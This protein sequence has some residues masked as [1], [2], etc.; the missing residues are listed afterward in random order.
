[1]LL[2]RTLDVTG[3]LM[4]ESVCENISTPCSA[5]GRC[6]EYL[7]LISAALALTSPLDMVPRRL[8]VRKVWSKNEKSVRLTRKAGQWEIV[9]PMRVRYGHLLY[10]RGVTGPP[11]IRDL[12]YSSNKGGRSRRD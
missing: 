11:R 9:H 8:R 6:P 5:T 7:N 12:P 3:E 10:P 4:S 2:D 1:M